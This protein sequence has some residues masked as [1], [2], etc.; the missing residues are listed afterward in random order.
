MKRCDEFHGNVPDLR[1]LL[2]RRSHLPVQHKIV[3]YVDGDGNGSSLGHCNLKGSFIEVMI[4]PSSRNDPAEFRDRNGS[5]VLGEL[6]S[7]CRLMDGN[8]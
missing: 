7:R 2:S 4:A 6:A 1:T 3:V 8:N 5:F